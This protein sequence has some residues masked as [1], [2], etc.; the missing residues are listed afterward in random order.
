M[1][2]R[3][4]KKSISNRLL[5]LAALAEGQS[6]IHDLLEADDTAVMLDSLQRLGCA[7][8]READACSDRYDRDPWPALLG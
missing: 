5:L 1:L 6:R 2:S 4:A 3:S 7:W 8:R